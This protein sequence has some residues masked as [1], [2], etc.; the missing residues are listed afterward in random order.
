MINDLTTYYKIYQQQYAK[1]HKETIKMKCDFVI[2]TQ[3]KGFCLLCGVLCTEKVCQKCN[4][5]NLTQAELCVINRNDKFD[6]EIAQIDDAN[7]E[8]RR[9]YSY[10]FDHLGSKYN[11]FDVCKLYNKSMV[12]CSY[13]LDWLFTA[14][15]IESEE[16]FDNSNIESIYNYTLLDKNNAYNFSTTMDPIKFRISFNKMRILNS[17][18]HQIFI[19]YKNRV[20]REQN[21]TFYQNR[22]KYKIKMINEQ[23]DQNINNLNKAIENNQIDDARE[24]MKINEKL[25]EFKKDLQLKQNNLG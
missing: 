1:L 17:D 22:I 23:I 3:F 24:F 4:K 12:V 13:V 5:Y 25:T 2:N 20:Q 18:L 19:N 15:T 7:M 21:I 9:Y 11:A 6:E 10:G 14:D 8:N 16:L